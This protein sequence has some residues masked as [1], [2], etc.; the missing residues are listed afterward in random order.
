MRST[1]IAAAVGAAVAGGVVVRPAHATYPGDVG[2][3]AFGMSVGGSPDI[4]SV[5]RNGHDLRQLTTDPGFDACPAYAPSGR[6]IVF[7]SAR[8]GAF[9]IWAMDANGHDQRQVTHLNA[10]ATFP[11][12]S[13]D[14]TKVAFDASGVN[15]DDNDEIY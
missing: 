1:L 15:R 10:F 3:L 4:Y 2:R 5:L 13:P 7:C 12:V 8:S 9:E 6:T 11:D 14:G